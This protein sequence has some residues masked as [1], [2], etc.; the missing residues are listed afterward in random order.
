MEG[1]YLRML[2]SE[3]GQ[4]NFVKASGYSMLTEKRRKNQLDK[5]PDA[6]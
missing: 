3:F 1:A 2:V 4:E 6:K 5:L